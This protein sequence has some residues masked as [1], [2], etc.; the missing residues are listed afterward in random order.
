MR[1]KNRYHFHK[2]AFAIDIMKQKITKLLVENGA[3]YV[4]QDT[5]ALF[6]GTKND[7]EYEYTIRF[8]IRKIR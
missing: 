3:V 6:V 7:G 1:K 4:K 8:D 5:D 2:Q